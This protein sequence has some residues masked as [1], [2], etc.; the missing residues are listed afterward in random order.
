MKGLPYTIL[1]PLCS[2][3]SGSAK[4]GYTFPV[5]EED[6]RD[7]LHRSRSEEKGQKVHEQYG[8]SLIKAIRTPSGLK[9][10]PPAEEYAARLF[11]PTYTVPEDIRD[12]E[13]NLIASEG[14][15]VDPMADKT[16]PLETLILF[17]GTD[18]DHVKWAKGQPDAVWILV[19]GSPV[20]LEENEEHPVYFDQFGEVGKRFGIERYP[21][22]LS[23][24]EGKI[25]IEEIPVR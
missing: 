7:A 18:P 19:K 4:E 25:L 9:E 1:L 15:K 3:I 12:L 10:V 13:G 6:I 20:T 24:K 17:D 2:F 14:S 5:T 22:R 8:K 21:C 23:E 11:D 16:T